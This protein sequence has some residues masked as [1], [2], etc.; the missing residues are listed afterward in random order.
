MTL[1][2]EPLRNEL[3]DELNRLYLADTVDEVAIFR[4]KQRAQKLKAVDPVGAHTVLG[5]LGCLT[6]NEQEM[7]ENHKSAIR[8]APG[9]VNAIKNFGTSLQKTNFYSDALGQWRV[10]YKIAPDQPEIVSSYIDIAVLAGCFSEALSMVHQWGIMHPGKKH[11]LFGFVTMAVALL[12]KSELGDS[13]TEE[14]QKVVSS[15]LSSER[16]R[17]VE[18]FY[19]IAGDKGSEAVVSEFTFN[20]PPDAVS[21][22]NIKVVDNI[23]D[24]FGAG[25]PLSIVYMFS[26]HEKQG[27]LCQSRVKSF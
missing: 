3:I 24:K 12:S 1:Q 5:M 26:P 2:P 8:R 10:L 25:W 17:V 18:N 9:D 7:R 16:A 11:S 22:L 20:L 13:E 21:D 23:V 4:I 27:R 19:T 6:W 15:V 14:F